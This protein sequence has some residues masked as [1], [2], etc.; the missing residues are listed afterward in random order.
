MD[1]VDPGV[2]RVAAGW[3][4][5]GCFMDYH[6]GVGDIR[7][8]VSELVGFAEVFADTKEQSLGDDKLLEQVLLKSMGEVPRA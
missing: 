7:G 5:K 1:S 6:A 8:S 3:V 2:A 4:S